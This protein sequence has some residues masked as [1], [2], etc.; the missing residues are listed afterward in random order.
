MTLS[1]EENELLA[2]EEM[3]RMKLSEHDAQGNAYRAELAEI[4]K[5]K[6]KKL[7]E[8]NNIEKNIEFAHMKLLK[9]FKTNYNRIDLIPENAF[10]FYSDQCGESVDKLK[11]WL[12]Q[13]ILKLPTPKSNDVDSPSVDEPEPYP[14]NSIEFAHMKLLKSLQ[15]NYNG[16]DMIPEVLFKA[17]SDQCGE[18]VDKLKEW[19]RQEIL[20]LPTP[21][22][23]DVDIPIVNEPEPYPRNDIDFIHMKLLEAFKMNFTR[24]DLVPANVFEFYSDQCGEP[25][26]KLKEW[27]RN[28]ISIRRL[29]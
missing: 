6:A 20:K 29:A 11:E 18:S 19:L 10:K 28:E 15:T 7:E 4:E 12:R 5:I 16:I 8:K 9:S 2:R 24:I 13:E 1:G 23:N 17:Y 26:E 27:L 21:K 25:V 3:V 14:R 22:S